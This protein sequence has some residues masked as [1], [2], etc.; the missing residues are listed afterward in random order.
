MALHEIDATAQSIGRLSSRIAVLLRGKNTADYEP[1]R[2]GGNDVI[3]LNLDKASFT[4]RKFKQKMYHR[5]S[6]YP[7]GVHSRT[8]EQMWQKNPKEVVRKAVYRML[9]ANRTRDKLIKNL[10]FK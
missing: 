1:S 10:K 9:P 4:G 8:L 3:V 2:A 7:G 6:G 5:Y